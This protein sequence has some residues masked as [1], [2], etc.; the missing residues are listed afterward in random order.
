MFWLAVIS[1][2]FLVL[3]SNRNI[4]W[5][6]V[7]G[8]CIAVYIVGISDD[9][10]LSK[11]VAYGYVGNILGYFQSYLIGKRQIFLR[12]FEFSDFPYNCSR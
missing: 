8:L 1:P 4:G 6:M 11:I 9:L 10:F 7:I 3:F 12:I 5:A 2:V